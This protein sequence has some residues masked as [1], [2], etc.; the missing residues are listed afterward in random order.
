MN[1][2]E[3]IKNQNRGIASFIASGFG[4]GY[5]P[6]APGTWGSL[7]GIPLGLL[8]LSVP[9][10]ASVLGCFALAF[11]LSPL[12]K[13]ATIELDDQDAPEIVVDEIIGQ[14]LTLQILKQYAVGGYQ[15][16]PILYIIWAFI[17]FRIFDIF[18]PFPANLLDR[19]KSVLGLFG[20]DL[21]AGLYAALVLRGLIK[22]LPAL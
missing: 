10:Y 3:H 8:L 4:L 12:V 11:L 15:N 1:S 16:L 2:T 5:L 6:G 7:L 20:D 13:K 21:V 17:L 9:V 19:Q 14:A 22:I 18:K